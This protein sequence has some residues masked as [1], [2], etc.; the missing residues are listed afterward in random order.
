MHDD[1][2]PF[3][4][5]LIEMTAGPIIWF[6]HLVVVYGASSL[7]CALNDRV[8]DAGD[9][10]GV[11]AVST[12]AALA[13]SVW[14]TL[15]A[16]RGIR[17]PATLEGRSFVDSFTIALGTF[18]I[19]AIVWTA[20][21]AFLGPGCE[22]LS[23]P[24]DAATPRTGDHGAAGGAAAAGSSKSTISSNPGTSI[25]ASCSVVSTPCAAASAASRPPPRSTTSGDAVSAARSGAPFR[26]RTRNRSS[27]VGL[28]SLAPHFRL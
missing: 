26:W 15:R 3:L 11:T 18:A 20:L 17:A 22:S 5:E 24:P 28:P 13:A 23:Q 8:F 16:A 12:I 2:K 14:L 19:M 9:V 6:A 10:T 21:P 27:V 7:A 1:T 4:G 25:L